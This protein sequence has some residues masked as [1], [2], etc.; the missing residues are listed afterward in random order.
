MEHA[1]E[2]ETLVEILKNLESKG[3][4]FDFGSESSAEFKDKIGIAEKYYYSPN[5]AEKTEAI[6][7]LVREVHRIEGMSDPSDNCIIY[8]IETTNGLKG[9][10]VN[11]YGIYSEDKEAEQNAICPHEISEEQIYDNNKFEAQVK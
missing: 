4:T 1:Q 7:L 3:Y 10:L 11:A 9:F 5:L 2:E 6:P 8:A